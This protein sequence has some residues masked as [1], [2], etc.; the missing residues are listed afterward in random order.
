MFST[1]G[2]P[3]LFLISPLIAFFFHVDKVDLL[4]SV[5][6]EGEVF[7][8]FERELQERADDIIKQRIIELLKNNS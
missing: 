6:D 2:L 3:G 5:S 4:I 1:I 8:T 7:L